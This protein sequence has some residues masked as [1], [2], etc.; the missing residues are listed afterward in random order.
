LILFNGDIGVIL[1]VIGVILLILG[2]VLKEFA[3]LSY[4]G[5]LCLIAGV[6][7]FVIELFIGA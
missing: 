3:R 5:K 7:I 6:V 1:I 2:G 4:P